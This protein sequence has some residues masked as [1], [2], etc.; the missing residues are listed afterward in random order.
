MAR[1]SQREGMVRLS[2]QCDGGAQVLYCAYG[3]DRVEA[4]GVAALIANLI[5]SSMVPHSIAVLMCT[6]GQS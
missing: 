2:S 5:T 6:N 1:S 4:E 3:D